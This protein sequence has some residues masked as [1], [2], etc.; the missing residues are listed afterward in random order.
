LKC[1]KCNRDVELYPEKNQC[2]YCA[3]QFSQET[4]NSI[5]FYNAIKNKLNKLESTQKTFYE[6]VNELKQELTSFEEIIYNA[7]EFKNIRVKEILETENKDGAVTVNNETV[8]IPEKVI[9]P[10]K[11]NEL[12]EKL[13]NIH[14]ELL[15]GF[16]GLLILGVISIITGVGFFIR[17]A[18][19]SDMLGPIGKV[20][21]IYLSAL[22]SL[23]V[24][25]F[26][27][28]KKMAEFGT[29]IIG[30]GI[31]L[32]YYSTYAAFAKYLIFNQAIAFTL[33][34][35]ITIFSVFMSVLENNRW[36]AVLGLI[37][38][39]STPFMIDSD[40]GNNLVLYS[41]ITILNIGLLS[42]AFNKK[43]DILTGLGFVSTYLLYLKTFETSEFWL[44]TIFVN[45]FFFIYSF[46]PLAY[47]MF[48]SEKEDIK[49]SSLIFLNS[50]VSLAINYYL[51]KENSFPIEYLAIVTV[52]YTLNFTLMASYLYK[53][54][55]KDEQ[56]F[57]FTIGK[58]ALFLSIT[59]PIIFSGE[60]ITVF[61]AAESVVLLWI[62]EKLNNK[63]LHYA[64][65]IMMLLSTFKFFLV[66]Y[67]ENFGVDE[68][69]IPD[70]Y[71]YKIVA[72][73]FSSVFLLAS[74]YKFM[75]LLKNSKLKEKQEF[76]I[77]SVLGLLS[78]FVITNVEVSSLF[79]TYA[80]FLRFVAVSTLWALFGIVLMFFGLKRDNP[81]IRKT[82]I[83]IFAITIGKVF[84]FDIAEMSAS[85]KFISFIILG[86]ILIFASYLYRQFK[87]QIIDTL[88][89]KGNK[90]EEESK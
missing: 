45:I 44:S 17:K 28:T 80:N 63:K 75:D 8:K 78:L 61:W 66:D 55:R 33:M 87:Q 86:I 51:I 90:D 6:Q 71:R 42:I 77:F 64:S 59:V 81:F 88:E 60:V 82:S 70:G 10:K 58:A 65:Y 34:T 62:A 9:E 26:F 46:M 39:F 85:Y 47:Y 54:N 7:P 73:L 67:H 32:L 11:K 29:G 53:H 18:F 48:K 68:F 31:A 49:N 43:W 19:V 23:G 21:I 72:R 40:V 2:T 3:N 1:P 14:W 4:A 27:R 84:F 25:N 13:Q 52:L 30:M 83:A 16:N 89:E 41:Y 20:S 50:F 38:G 79:Y 69:I 76:A 56:T 5:N 57:I 15:L 36:L 24:G 74:Y 22:I 35:V 12:L 37:G